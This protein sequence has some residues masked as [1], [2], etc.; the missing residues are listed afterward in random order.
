[1]PEYE[2]RASNIPTH[3]DFLRGYLECA[4]W[5]GLSGEDRERFDHAESPKFSLKALSQARTDCK[6]FVSSNRADLA[7]LN[8]SQAGHDF[9]LTRNRHGAGF[10]D[11]GYPEDIGRRLT[12]AAH[13]YGGVDVFFWRSIKFS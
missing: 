12:D 3:D 9:W 1:M 2:V 13:V 8:M 6:D 4:E 11:G 5:S 7:G 10:W